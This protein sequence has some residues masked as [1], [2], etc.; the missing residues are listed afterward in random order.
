[1]YKTLL[2]IRYLRR[3]RIAWVSLLAVTLC[4]AMVL[5]V[6]SVMGGWL[7]MFRQS[8]HGMNG[9]II[10]RDTSMG[11][12]PYY[13]EMAE[14]IRALPGVKAAVPEISA[15]G[16]INIW[17]RIQTYV[18]VDGFPSDQIGLVNDW[19]QSL[20]RQHHQL[21]D[22]ADDKTN[23]LTEKERAD[24]RKRAA[25]V[26]NTDAFAKPL[27]AEAY[28]A[29]IPGAKA[30]VSSWPGMIAGVGVVG[31]NKGEDGKIHRGVDLTNVWA[32]LTLMPNKPDAASAD[33][34]AVNRNYWMVDDS[35]TGIFETDRT[36]VYVPFD[37]L[38]KDLQMDASEATDVA[39]GKTV[40]VPARASV[41]DVAL[42]AGVQ[43]GPVVAQIQQIVDD[44][45]ASKGDKRY[46][47]DVE[48]WEQGPAVY[49]HAI[50]KEK[51]LVTVLFSLISVV[52]VFLIFCIFYM[53]VA[54]KTK[55]IGIL[56]SVGATSRGVASIYLGFGLSIGLGGGMLGLLVGYEVV[57]NINYLH[58]M[59]GKLMGIQI[60]SPETYMFDT[61]PN[62][63]NWHE[64]II[65]V[66]VAVISSVLG[67]LVPALRAARMQPIEA[68][69]FE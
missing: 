39:T 67:A 69:R 60:W 51:A 27:D 68:L 41:L 55:D 36:T 59:M 63:M 14:K 5:V 48:T 16:L 17:G 6:I 56:K 13:Q 18:A 45:V 53:I 24:L 32:K 25:D 23:G 54:E 9:D 3:R 43:A 44:V 33:L 12:F 22:E 37:V 57:H 66:S 35:R 28:K 49:L 61:I 38:Q 21:L 2:I 15:Y 58:T 50:E 47:I 52:A 7:R 20:Y 42:N 31:F 4:T 8:L 11:G 30:D 1:M 10:V 26:V 29:M 34:Q 64:V 46:P 65:I 62:T 19:P 40:Q